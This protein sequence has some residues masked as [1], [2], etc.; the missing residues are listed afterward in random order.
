MSLLFLTGLGTASLKAQVRIGGDGAPNAAA[1][2]DLNANNDATPA[3]NKGALALPRVSLANNTTQLNGATPITGM[4]VYNTGGSLSA[5][6]Y[7]WD[8]SKWVK[9]SS[10]TDEGSLIQ[11][12]ADTLKI[13]ATLRWNGTAFVADT[14]RWHSTSF[15]VSGIGSAVGSTK[16]VAFADVLPSDWPED[17]QDYSH[18]RIIEVGDGNWAQVMW[19]VYSK[20]I[21][22]WR[23]RAESKSPLFNVK[24]FF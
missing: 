23:V 20:T 8:S 3:A 14:A 6:V 21:A 19:G 17:C 4:L 10:S 22:I 2:L 15:W 1:V 18:P 7:Y 24:C 11:V 9:S 12:A 16:T 5:G 13:G